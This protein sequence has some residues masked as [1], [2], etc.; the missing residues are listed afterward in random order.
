VTG[1]AGSLQATD[2]GEFRRLF[3]DNY[4]YVWS[5][6]RRLGIHERDLEDVTHEV[7]LEVYKKRDTRDASR[8][9]RPWL[10]AFAVRIAS[11]YRKAARHR[12]ELRADVDPPSSA[13]SQ[14][15]ALTTKDNAKL[16]GEALD[17]LSLELRAVIVLYEID[18]VPMKDIADALGIPLFTAY[19]RLRLARAQ[20]AE[21]I[22][23]ITKGG[24]P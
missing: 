12:T 19:S 2:V 7:F 4:D 3:D 9:I 6:L 22:R 13:P 20:C 8:P 10:F 11:D 21:R 5:S 23:R 15:D 16:L 18:E 14:E 24:I 17:A 1:P